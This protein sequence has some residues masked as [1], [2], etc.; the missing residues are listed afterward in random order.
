MQMN[1]L[2]FAIPGI[3][4]AIA[5]SFVPLKVAYHK[6]MIKE[7]EIDMTEEENIYEIKN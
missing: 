2:S 5:F 7:K 4:A 3:I 1:F 6:K